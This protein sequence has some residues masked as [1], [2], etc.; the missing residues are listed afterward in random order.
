MIRALLADLRGFR[1][2]GEFEDDISMVALRI[3]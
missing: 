1:G 3:S 2:K